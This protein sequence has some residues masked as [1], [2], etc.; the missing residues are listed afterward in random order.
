MGIVAESMRKVA[1][2]Y[3]LFNLTTVISYAKDIIL[4]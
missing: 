4:L 3:Y 2:F 1:F